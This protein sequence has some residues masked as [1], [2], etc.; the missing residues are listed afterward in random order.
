MMRLFPLIFVFLWSSAFISGKIIVADA[1]PFASLAFRFAIVAAGFYLYSFFRAETFFGSRSDTLSACATGVLFHGFYLGGVF[2]AV[3]KGLPAGI[4]AL[5][6]SLQPVLTGALAGPVLG[7]IVTWRQWVGICLGFIGAALVLGLDIGGDLP[8][9]GVVSSVVALAA[10]TIGT[11]W[12]KKLS[13]NLPLSVS[14][15]YQA[16]GAALFHIFVM[17]VFEEPSISF[18]PSFILSMGWQIIL[19]SF[20]AFTILMYLISI[21]SASRTATMFFLV[22]PISAVMAWLVVDEA[23]TIMDIAG[24]F[25]A[26]TGVYIAT[27][28]SAKGQNNKKQD[29]KVK[30]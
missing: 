13:G 26:T 15:L 28:V 29:M 3:S 4:A 24:L 25:I 27:R 16:V 22:P 5:I 2:F 23:L 17:L 30:R 6:V 18:T 19:V 8:I 21:G 14:N 7:E 12:Q 20:G 11:L 10:V 1:T 9:I